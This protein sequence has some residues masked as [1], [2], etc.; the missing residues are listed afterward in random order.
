MNFLFYMYIIYPVCIKKATI[1]MIAFIKIC[2]GIKLPQHQH[3][4]LSA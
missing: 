1:E 3:Q 2:V 4:L